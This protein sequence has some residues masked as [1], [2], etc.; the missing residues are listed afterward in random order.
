MA[1]TIINE[2]QNM[3]ISHF[4]RINIL[5]YIMSLLDTRLW[6]AWR[7]FWR[8]HYFL[9]MH[10]IFALLNSMAIVRS[11]MFVIWAAVE[12]KSRI[13]NIIGSVEFDFH[14]SKLGRMVWITK[15]A[16]LSVWLPRQLLSL[17]SKLA[18]YFSRCWTH[19]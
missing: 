12:N 14:N 7:A 2:R 19:F 4:R 8:V 10:S 16:S 1:T 5:N 11:Y 6:L 13:Q 3:L 17:S 9:I 18:S 15:L